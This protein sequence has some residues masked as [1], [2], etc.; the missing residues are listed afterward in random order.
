LPYGRRVEFSETVERIR[1]MLGD[2][3][4]ATLF[5]PDGRTL[6][7]W[8]GEL[9]E[10]ELDSEGMADRLESRVAGHEDAERRVRALRDGEVALFT[11]AGNPLVVDRIDTKAAEAIEPAGV[12]MRDAEGMTVEL[13]PVEIA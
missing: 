12:R 6:A 13:V 5:A 10:E 9:A 11:V 7:R 3:V 2:E 8:Q 1:S 4:R